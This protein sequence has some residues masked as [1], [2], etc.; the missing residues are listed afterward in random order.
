MESQSDG[1]GQDELFDAYLDALLRGDEFAPDAFL[2]AHG[3]GGDD[4]LPG[5]LHDVWGLVQGESKP[6]EHGPLAQPDSLPVE[7]VGAFRLLRPIGEGGMGRVYLAMQ[8]PLGRLCA[9]K[10]LRPEVANSPTATARLEREARL[11]ASLNHNHILRVLEAGQA[12]GVAW[13]AFELVPGKNLD[14]VCAASKPAVN[15]IVVWGQELAGALQH[16]H[17]QGIVHRDVKPSNVRITPEGRALLLDF[18]L[19]RNIDR[20]SLQLTHAF[21]GTPAYVAPEQVTGASFDG[22]CDVYGLGATLYEAFVGA[23]PFEGDSVE[24]VLHAVVNEDPIPPKQRGVQ[25]PGDLEVILL[26][27]LEKDPARRYQSARAM[28]EDL[29]AVLELRPIQARRATWAARATKWAR[30]NRATAGS[31]AVLVVALVVWL[32]MDWKRERNALR[33]DQRE[34]LALIQQATDTVNSYS[35]GR[36]D[37]E[38]AV[39]VVI[40][41]RSLMGNRHVK[42]EELERMAEAR[43]QTAAYEVLKVS[44]EEVPVLLGRADRLFPDGPGSAQV[45]AAFWYQL[46]MDVRD[47]SNRQL[48]NHYAERIRQVDPSGEWAE[49]VSGRVALQISSDPPGA[50]VHLYKYHELEE[51]GGTRFVPKPVPWSDDSLAQWQTKE[52]I[53]E[54]NE[55]ELLD[56]AWSL[57]VLRDGQG[58]KAGDA[59]VTVAGFEVRGSLL[60]WG[61]PPGGDSRWMRLRRVGE[62]PL[63]DLWTAG[64]ALTAPDLQVSDWRFEWVQD[65]MAMSCA[66]A[67]LPSL[68]DMRTPEQVVAGGSV[69]VE[70]QRDG[71]RTWLQLNE[72]VETRTTGASLVLGRSALVGNTPLEFPATDPGFYVAM[73]IREGH[74]PRRLSFHIDHACEHFSKGLALTAKLDPVGTT[75]KGFVFVDSSSLGAKVESFWMGRTEVTCGQYLEFLNDQATEF[76][77]P[78]AV[79][80]TQGS[81]QEWPRDSSGLV[82]LPNG[83]G[84]DWPML[85]VNAAQARAFAAWLDAKYAAQGSPFSAALPTI[86]EWR[87]A[88]YGGDGRDY[89]HGDQFSSSWVKGRYARPWPTPEPVGSFPLDESPWGILDMAGSASEWV[90]QLEP[91][92][93]VDSWALVGGAWNMAA[94]LDFAIAKTRYPDD[95]AFDAGAGIRIVLHRRP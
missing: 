39:R 50:Q 27:A 89:V 59:I 60:F 19:A 47:D 21:T 7:R 23:P 71:G 62:G 95:D 54:G 53:A 57:G 63:P 25:L 64:Q 92:R 90:H 41:A 77:L 31:L 16:A 69:D 12:E 2:E 1:H 8:E 83:M 15:Q 87:W 28:G 55:E 45:W 65:F 79:L 91:E 42:V 56:G 80:A 70:V 13:V 36:S 18:G 61:A 49:K 17:D 43:K 58:L 4:R 82:Q 26:H 67:E 88:G 10:L 94:P 29:R 74:E 68:Q 32:A 24:R 93:D 46:W 3:A 34:A 35:E 76:E 66:A 9:V 81:S 5:W 20:E 51:V 44:L 84:L 52:P 48:A 73:L 37:Y 30:R 75:P 33:N 38:R 40:A 11:V 86:F 85:G 14:E 72:G 78:K 22:R 6:G